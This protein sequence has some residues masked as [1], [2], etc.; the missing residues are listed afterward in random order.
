LAQVPSPTLDLIASIYLSTRVMNVRDRIQTEVLM[1]RKKASK[2]THAKK[3]RSN[4]EAKSKATKAAKTTKK[5]IVLELLRRKEGATIAD[6]AK[7][8]EWQTHSIRGFLSG[9]V[10]KKL[11]LK[12]ES[13]KSDAGERTYRINA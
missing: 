8:T 3:V 2:A 1:T 11:G 10:G 9:M 12:L 4:G 13:E 5:H 7:A 6:I